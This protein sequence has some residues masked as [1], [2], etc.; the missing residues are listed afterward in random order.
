MKIASTPS[1]FIFAALL[2]EV[3][4]LIQQ[5]QLTKYPGKHPFGIY[6]NQQRVVVIT[7]IGKVAM[8]GAVGYALSLFSGDPQAILLN[9]G[10]AG[11]RRHPLGSLFLADK[12]IDKDSG[13][14]FY[15]QL[16]FKVSCQT[17]A[18]QTLSKPLTDYH[19]DYLC[20]MEASAFYE[21]AGKF[22]SNELIH[23]LKIVSDNAQSSPAQINEALV[24]DWLT[25]QL[26]A[27]EKVISAL[28]KLVQH[29]PASDD[30]LLQL[31]TRQFHFTSSNTIKLKGLLQRWQVLNAPAEFDLQ[32]F[33]AKNGKDL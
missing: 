15:P 12:I 22:S 8:A 19:E 31:L 16:P 14:S 6:A 9:I 13:K 11:H 27:I 1:L 30:S 32:A 28:L 5:Q 26:E 29:L 25:Q 20:D 23:S 24:V 33:N 7:G 3:K 17:A 2:C 18:I 4:P 10:I 21:I